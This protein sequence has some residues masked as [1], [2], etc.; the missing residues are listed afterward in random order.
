[1]SARLFAP[2]GTF[3][4]VSAG[5]RS[6]PSQVWAAGISPFG[7]KAGEVISMAGPPWAVRGATSAATASA[8][9]AN[10]RVVGRIRGTLTTKLG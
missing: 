7:A 1:M 6:A 8:K 5:A 3:A 10:A 4:N 9:V 2:G